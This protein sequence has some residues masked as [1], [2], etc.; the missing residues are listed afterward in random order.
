MRHGEDAMWLMP[1]DKLLESIFS[2]P[3]ERRTSSVVRAAALE[4]RAGAAPPRGAVEKAPLLG[5]V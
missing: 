5:R 3:R 4:A 1:A 2:C